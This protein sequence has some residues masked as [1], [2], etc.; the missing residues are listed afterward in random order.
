VP[1]PHGTYLIVCCK[2]A[3]G[4]L[5]FRRRDSNAFGRGQHNRRAFIARKL[6]YETGNI[7]LCV[8]GKRTRN[9]DGLIE[10]LGR[11]PNA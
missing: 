7:I 11:G 1:G 2:L 10:Q 3:P 8:C 9:L 6:Q 5:S 4:R